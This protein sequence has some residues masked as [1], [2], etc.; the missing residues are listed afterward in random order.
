MPDQKDQIIKDLITALE[1]LL[2]LGTWREVETGIGM[3]PEETEACD[4]A[5]AAI[6]NAKAAFNEDQA[7]T[8][9]M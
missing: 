4:I 9:S 8:P 6:A 2:E 5:R 1:F 7:A 3:V